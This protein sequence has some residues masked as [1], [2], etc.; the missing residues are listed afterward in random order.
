[1]SFDILYDYFANLIII[2]IV[3]SSVVIL[4]SLVMYIMTA[5][6]LYS[7]ACHKGYK[8]QAIFAWIPLANSYLSGLLA[9]EIDFFGKKITNLKTV[10]L[11]ASILSVV[12]SVIPVINFIYSL[13][14][15]ILGIK[16]NIKI[17][18]YYEPSKAVSYG[19][20]SFIGFFIIG[21]NLRE[22]TT[23]T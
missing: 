21:R 7:I 17:A 2:F 12:I 8:S 9:E 5:I 16:I 6:G 14:L 18:W 22:S 19:L 20:F 3:V 23:P 11:V 13:F 15:L 10:Y 1:M 4:I